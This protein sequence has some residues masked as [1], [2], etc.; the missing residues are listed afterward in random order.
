[1]GLIRI[2]LWT[3]SLSHES[4]PV[5]TSL[6][7]DRWIISP[8]V[9]S[10]FLECFWQTGRLGVD[11]KYCC[12]CV[13]QLGPPSRTSE[14]TPLPTIQTDILDAPSA[15]SLVKMEPEILKG[16]IPAGHIPRPV[17]IADYVA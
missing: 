9:H 5:S 1:M 16:H 8:L 4:L 7:E 13:L 11:L 14:A 12:D 17:V 15:A 6:D 3:V 10:E 2:V